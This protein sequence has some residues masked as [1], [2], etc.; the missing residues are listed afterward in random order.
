MKI[1]FLHI[2]KAA[3]T[4]FH[5]A[6]GSNFQP[7]EV[8]PLRHD[9]QYAGVDLS[10][11]SD[12]YKFFSGHINF[13]TFQKLGVKNLIAIIRDPV[14]RVISIY[15]Y[16]HNYEPGDGETVMPNVLYAK[17]NSF[18]DWI[19]TENK[20]YL[21]DLSNGMVRQFSGARGKNLKLTHSDLEIALENVQK[22]ELVDFYSM[23]TGISRLEKLYDISINL[24]LLNTS[25]Y[26]KVIKDIADQDL[27][28]LKSLNEFD[29]EFYDYA[30][31][32][33]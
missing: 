12:N 31:S 10:E 6:V 24:P 5:Q 1:G 9:S 11:L 21:E 4:S 29:I 15:N 26:T 8:C 30:K 13:D 18:S 28:Y 33:L 3:G 2:P 27:E 17:N 23:E 20:F 16:H 32:L 14:S 25:K 7:A 19:R 22:V